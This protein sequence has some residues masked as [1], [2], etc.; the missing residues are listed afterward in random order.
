MERRKI[1]RIGEHSS[2]DD[3]VCM[4]KENFKTENGR[5]PLSDAND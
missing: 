4:V 5:G 3:R 2:R 1:Y